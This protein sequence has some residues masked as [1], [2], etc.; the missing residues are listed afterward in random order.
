MKNRSSFFENISVFVWWHLLTYFLVNNLKHFSKN[1]LV[2]LIF[3]Y[4]FFG[5]TLF[6]FAFWFC[7]SLLFEICSC[8][9]ILHNMCLFLC[10]R[11]VSY[12][13]WSWKH[14]LCVG[15]IPWCAPGATLPDHQNE[16][17]RG[18]FCV[19]LVYPA[20]VTEPWLCWAC[21]W[22]SWPSARPP[23]IIYACCGHIGQDL[24]PVLLRDLAVSTVDLLVSMACH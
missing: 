2:S 19:D 11:L 9:F 24:L 4:R 10:V 13:S 5:S 22:L 8:L 1:H 23:V 12:V 18:V 21:W 17:P 3:F 16:A 14:L 20:V 15:E 6:I 7:I